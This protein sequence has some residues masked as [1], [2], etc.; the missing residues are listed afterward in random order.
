[1]RRLV[2]IA[3]AV[4]VLVVAVGAV[5]AARTDTTRGDEVPGTNCPTE[6]SNQLAAQTVPTASLVPCV[7]FLGGRWS[8]TSESYTDDGTTISMMMEDAPDIQWS[9]ELAPSCDINQL[10]PRGESDG[11]S[12][13]EHEDQ[14]GSSFER[15][16]RL[17][18]DGGCV[19]STIDMPERFDRR[20]VLEDVDEALMFVDR[21][22]LDAQVRDQTSGN[23]SLDP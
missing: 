22:A 2:V 21:R 10:T 13:F 23:L 4:L 1:M 11:A 20:L 14:S 9:V 16:Q 17:V 15:E 7:S 6:T 8:I 18:F 19:T 3:V 12:L 5:S